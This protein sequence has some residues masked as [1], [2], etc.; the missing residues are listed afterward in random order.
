MNVWRI[1]EWREPKNSRK[2]PRLAPRFIRNGFTLFEIIAAV[3]ILSLIAATLGPATHKHRVKAMQGRTVA[4][5]VATLLRAAR[6]TAI[7][8]QRSVVVQ[9]GDDTK[10]AWFANSIDDDPVQSGP[11]PGPLVMPLTLPTGSVVSGWPGRVVFDSRGIPDRGL[12]L[13]VGTAE[14]SYRLILYAASGL[15]RLDL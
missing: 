15:V 12:D 13:Q 8:K 3:V 10:G 4:S 11:A 7:G 9:V 1:T 6:A 14:R 5:E 2:C